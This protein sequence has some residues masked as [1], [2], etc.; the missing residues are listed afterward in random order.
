MLCTPAFASDAKKAAPVVEEKKPNYVEEEGTPGRGGYIYKRVAKEPYEEPKPVPKE[1]P[2]SE[3]KDSHSKTDAHGKP[4]EKK[5]DDSHG[6]PEEKKKDDGH[7]GGD[8][9]EPKKE[10][11]KKDDKK[12]D[13]GHGGGHAK[14]EKK[15]EPVLSAVYDA[16]VIKLDSNNRPFTPT[17]QTNAYADYF[18]CRKTISEKYK[19][20]V[21]DEIN[22]FADRM[23][24]PRAQDTPCMIKVAK[25]KT[26]FPGAIY[27]EFYV[28]EKAAKECIRS[29]ECASTRLVMLFPKDKTGVKS[30]EIYRSYVLTD[31]RKYVRSSFCVSPD[32]KL[33][34]E[35]NCYVALHPDWLFN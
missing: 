31:E 24:L 32:G 30:K 14:A 6:K 27:I 13:D 10:E 4:E 28:D 5:K 1:E 23:G 29:G 34:G 33:L 2:K 12:K 25:P 3:A 15:A 16:A 22:T 18:L 26:K 7:G 19:K 21:L 17:V 8:H 11:K 20:T 9:K 35:K